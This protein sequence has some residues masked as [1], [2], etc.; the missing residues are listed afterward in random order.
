MK[1]SRSRNPSAAWARP[2]NRHARPLP[3]LRR[4]QLPHRLRLP[5][6]RRLLQPA[7]KELCKERWTSASKIASSPSPEAPP[8][9]AK[10]SPAPA[11][12]KAPT[13]SSSAAHPDN[14]KRSSPRCK[15]QNLPVTSSKP[16]SP[17]PK[18]A[19]PPS[20]SSSRSTAAST[21]WSTT[22]ASTTASAS[23][24]AIPRASSR[25]SS[26]SRPLL[27]HGALRLCRCSRPR[28][29]PSSTSASKVALTGQG[30]TSGLRRRQGRRQLALT[31]EWAA[32]LLPFGIRVNSRPPRRGP[33]TPMTS[34]GSTPSPTPPPQRRRSPAASRSAIA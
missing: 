22:P 31:R 28:A 4:R 17:T 21:A 20:T 32:E 27:R 33:H 5:Y 19:A 6:R 29:A 25:A 12:T 15:Q 14:V 10:P 23:P 16:S 8:A 34:A 18:P 11:S 13:P 3:L 1:R 26:Q 9:S 24:P 7:L 2:T 30:N